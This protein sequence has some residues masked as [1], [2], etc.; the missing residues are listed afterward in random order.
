MGA[1]SKVAPSD[2]KLRS[3]CRKPKQPEQGGTGAGTNPPAIAASSKRS[4]ASHKSSSSGRERKRQKK[5]TAADTQA[6]TRLEHVTRI[7]TTFFRTAFSERNSWNTCTICEKKPPESGEEWCVLPCGHAFGHRCVRQFFLW[8][9]FRNCPT[10]VVPALHTCGHPVAPAMLPGVTDLRGVELM[11]GLKRAALHLD[12]QVR[13]A[14]GYCQ[15]RPEAD[16]TADMLL[17]LLYGKGQVPEVRSRIYRME[18]EWQV[19]WER[20]TD[21]IPMTG[22]IEEYLE[23]EVKLRL[24]WTDLRE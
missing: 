4:A 18:P 11:R 2:R 19:W 24:G 23:R 1:S 14:C 3:T 6:V 7:Q 10:C 9:S 13:S 20:G 15:E 12:E 16:E 5:E 17:D 21:N 8:P 22:K